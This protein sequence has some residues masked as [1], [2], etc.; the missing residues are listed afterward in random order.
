M[1]TTLF[2]SVLSASALAACALTFVP[3][4]RAEEPAGFA[5]GAMAG[6]GFGALGQWVLTMGF[7]RG[8]YAAFHG[9]TGGGWDIAIAPSADYFIASRISVGG[10]IGFRHDSAG[11]TNV[12][13]GGR[14][15]FS[16]AIS[17]PLTFWPTAGITIDIAHTPSAPNVPSNTNT[18]AFL[19]VF[20]PFL[21]HLVPHLFVGLGPSF[22]IGFNGG[23]N[24][25]GIDAVL[26]GWF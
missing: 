21:Y 10:V 22:D 6:A 13:L 25:F 4:A 11:D 15:G 20:A 17:G 3:R 8:E 5:P 2:R 23:G 26:G 1:K 7:D 9:H 12:N 16:L 18:N 14:G 19:R 24:T